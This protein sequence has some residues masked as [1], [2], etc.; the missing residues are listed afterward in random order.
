MRLK[1][2]TARL[3]FNNLYQFFNSE[4]RLSRSTSSGDPKDHRQL[5]RCSQAL[6]ERSDIFESGED[7]VWQA[8][9]AQRQYSLC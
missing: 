2:L 3:I 8:I 9:S 7:F 5:L 4:R 6:L 1:I